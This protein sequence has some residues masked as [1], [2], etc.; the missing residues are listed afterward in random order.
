MK[1][2]LV[3][4]LAAAFLLISLVSGLSLAEKAQKKGSPQ[5]RALSPVRLAVVI[6]VDGLSWPRLSEYRPYFTS[7]LKRLLD[8]GRT[9]RACRYQ[10]INT[11][12]G[13]GHAS[14]GTGA[15]PR[16]TGIVA[17]RW[18]EP[19][20]DGSLRQVYCTDQELVDP[21]TKD[22]VIVPGPRNL[23]VPTMADRLV[24]K[25]PD[26][27]VVAIS[28][29]D[30]GAIF[31]AGKNP[32]HAV[33]WWD[34][35]LG[36]FTSSA[37]YDAG[38]VTGAFVAPI[39]AKFN[40]TRAQGFLPGRI[41]LLWKKLS[42][43][44]SP[45]QDVKSLPKPANPAQIASYQVPANGLGWDK[46]VSKNSQGYYY[47]IYSSPFVDE[48]VT[49]LALAV[50]AD[51]NLEL[52]HRDVPD[53][54]ALSFSAQ[55]TVS[56]NYGPESEENLDT[57]RRL[58]L[59]L[60]RLLEALDEGFPDG[61]VLLALSADHGFTPIPEFQRR[62]D[63]T[64]SGG[65]VVNGSYPIFN[66]VARLNRYLAEELCLDPASR[67]IFGSDGWNL[68][69]NTPS[70]PSMRTLEG[71]CGPAGRSITVSDVDRV[72]PGAVS[73]LNQEEIQD[74]YLV[75]KRDSWND[76]NP[77]TSFVRN[78]FDAERSGEAILIPRPG[79]IIHWDPGRGTGH[80][81]QHETDTHV[82]LIFW[83]AGVPAGVSDQPSTPYDLAPTVGRMLGV[84]VPDAV[85]RAIPLPQ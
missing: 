44:F 46:D 81:S 48:L 67:V 17:N 18:F 69:Y 56:H 15:P 23:R 66:N 74:V 7:G 80:G 21:V 19:R 27:R 63:K 22:P 55:D 5:P 73:R 58:D 82:P 38:S 57:L 9:E 4:P 71:A 12:T 28:G 60:G 64:Y 8:E 75:S 6:S 33:Y 3:R 43:A 72:L 85:G 10:H 78:D 52:G 37:A 39:V 11:E 40:S 54:L 42:L 68:R 13:P 35:A 79:V 20:E 24:E 65:R 62:L 26:S 45:E 53:V 36:R 14:L 47:G 51:K 76:N 1:R 29:K 25:F 70:F 83:R 2:K 59:Q 84:A 61:K 31:L 49:D 30:R 41:G 32:S 34:Q 50:Q 77:A 16:V